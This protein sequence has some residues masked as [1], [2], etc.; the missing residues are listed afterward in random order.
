MEAQRAG[1]EHGPNSDQNMP[2]TD[3]L[4]VVAIGFASPSSSPVHGPRHL[5]S[6]PQL[7]HP[8]PACKLPLVGSY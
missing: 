4:Y 7:D 5:Q 2:E 6:G 8:I 1:R 3:F